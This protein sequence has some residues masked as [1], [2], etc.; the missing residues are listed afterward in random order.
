MTAPA[1]QGVF[2]LGAVH[3]PPWITIP[4]AA[5][6]VVG[7]VYYWLRLG[8]AAVPPTRRLIRRWSVAIMI[9]TCADLVVAL[10]FADHATRPEFYVAVWSGVLVLLFIIV[11][12][13]FVDLMNSLRLQRREFEHEAQTAASELSRILQH[14]A[15]QD[16]HDQSDTDAHQHEDR[17]R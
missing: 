9:V 8:H 15:T 4:I 6:V 14:R 10:S 3:F 17:R 5:V 13:A 11:L 2:M 1:G 16:G 7:L 12:I